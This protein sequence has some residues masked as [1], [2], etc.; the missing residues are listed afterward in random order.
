MSRGAWLE[1]TLWSLA[2]LCFLCASGFELGSASYEPGAHAPPFLRVVTWNVGGASGGEPHGF[3]RE[4][5]APVAEALSA[6]EPDLVFLEE[7]QD[8]GTL[9]ALAAELGPRWTLQKGRGGV[10]LFSTHGPLETWRMPLAR[11]LGVRLRVNGTELVC[12]ALHAS[13]F[14]AHDRNREIGAT[15]DALLEQSGDAFLLAGDLNLDLD[16]DKRSDFFSNDVQRDVET[17]NYVATRLADAA[18]GRGTTAEPDR[19][20]DYVFV[21][22]HVLVHGAGPWKG[23]RAGTMDHDPL[24]VDLELK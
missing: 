1:A 4:D 2:A 3:L 7:V 23:R 14:S 18:R 11:S 24:V 21:S 6:L 19:R 17:Y 13:A 8:A 9:D 10:A 20:L 5:V 12:A 16:L 22:A 15:L